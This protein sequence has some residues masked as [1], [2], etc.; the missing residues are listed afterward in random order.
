MSY[1]FKIIT[2]KDPDA[3]A[4]AVREALGARKFTILM[5]ADLGAKF[6]SL[7]LPPLKD[8]AGVR[9]IETCHAPTA[10]EVLDTNIEVA[11]FLPCKIVVRN[12]PL[13]EGGKA[14]GN[15]QT[16]IGLWKPSVFGPFLSDPTGK[17]AGA[18]STVE[19]TMMAAVRDAAGPG[20]QEVPATPGAREAIAQME[21]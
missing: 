4:A 19:E 20:S 18:M 5:E 8:G 13:V 7:G 12:M 1:A 14:T 2:N 16:E 17:L 15:M 9:L 10:K 21:V 3:A 11:Y 6:A